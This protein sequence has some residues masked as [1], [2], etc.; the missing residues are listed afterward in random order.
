[1]VDVVGEGAEVR[2]VDLILVDLIAD[3]AGLDTGARVLATG[4][5]GTGGA[6]GLD[7][8]VDNLRMGVKN[9][10]PDDDVPNMGVHVLQS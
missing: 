6:V 8:G 2:V 4:A 1:M 7:L 5:G 10:I 9:G 3:E